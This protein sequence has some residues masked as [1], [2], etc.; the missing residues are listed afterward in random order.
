MIL[1]VGLGNPGRDYCKT[2]HNIGFAVVDRLLEGLISQVTYYKFNAE[3]FEADYKNT[4]LLIVKPLTYM[5]NSGT[6]V[7]HFINQ[8]FSEIERILVIHDDIDIEFGLVK[9][10]IGGGS[11]GHNGLES[12]V[13]HLGNTDFDRLRFGIGRPP[14]KID[15]AAYVLS[16]FKRIELKSL[17]NIIDR[18][19]E[20]IKDYIEFG[21]DYAMNKYN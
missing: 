17:D 21:I 7:K 12:L 20:A 1:I 8:Y 11:G 13:K 14:K 2:R 19:A 18:A 4:K 5:N 9:L 3:V 6:S 16:G 10:K 15:P